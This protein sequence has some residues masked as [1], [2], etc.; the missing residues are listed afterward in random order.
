MKEADA[1]AEAGYDVS[2]IAA[3]FALWAR[4]EDRSFGGRQWRV[5]HILTFGPLAPWP[6]RIIQ[7]ARQRAAKL[8][9]RAGLQQQF[10]VE[11]AWHPITPDLIAIAKRVPADLYIAHYPAALPAAAIAARHHGARYSFDA[12]DFHLG[13][14]PEGPAYEVERVMLRAIE[15]CYLPGCTYVTA[16]SPGIADAYV[17]AYAIARPTVVLNVFPRAQAPSG[18][19]PAG[20][21]KPGPSVYWFSQ[22]IGPER[23]LECAVRAIGRA[24]SQPH[25][26][27]RG[28][29]AVGFTDRL[30]QIALESK[31]A[32]RLHFLSLAAPSEME[33]LAASYDVG[34]VGEA[35]YTPNRRIALTNKLFS[36]LLAGIPVLMSDVPAHRAF[37]VEA[38]TAAKLYSAENPDSLAAALDAQLRDPTA[39]S[40]ARTAAFTLGRDR[41][42]WDVEKHILLDCVARCGHF[43]SSGE[44]ASRSSARIR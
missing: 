24:K 9:M 1:L 41:F 43:A 12:E 31:V 44:S 26:Y 39:L 11:A 13:D 27:L 15:R 8:M 34:L 25:L 23:G 17:E 36:Y 3:D 22:T 28:N 21:A 14:A 38:G 29:P 32:D 5:A 7:L 40:N 16:A 42:N 20:T 37:A 18:S 2:V 35:G 4:V 33:R 10:V 30:R 6:S 19:T